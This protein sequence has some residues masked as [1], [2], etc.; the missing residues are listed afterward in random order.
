MKRSHVRHEV[1][2]TKD[3]WYFS[4]LIKHLHQ[5]ASLSSGATRI[6][7]TLFEAINAAIMGSKVHREEELSS[8]PIEKHKL[9]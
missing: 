4:M 1:Y 2:D 8:L 6:H 7:A 3:L 9:I 5:P